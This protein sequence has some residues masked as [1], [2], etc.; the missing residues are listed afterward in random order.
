MTHVR[1]PTE[2]AEYLKKTL[3]EDLQATEESLWHHGHENP[4]GCT[5]ACYCR[6]L[7]KEHEQLTKALEVLN[8]ATDPQ[9]GDFWLWV[10]KH[11]EKWEG[12]TMFDSSNPRNLELYKEW[13]EY[14][15]LPR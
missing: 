3:D 2:V 11:P 6:D 9:W 10:A 4:T 1:I 7:R 13:R 8:F 12:V 5:K 15:P 14:T